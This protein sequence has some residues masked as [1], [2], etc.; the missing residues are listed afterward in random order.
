MNLSSV[1][2]PGTTV[3]GWHP[4]HPGIRTITLNTVQ[5]VLFILLKTNIT[6]TL[7]IELNISKH[8]KQEQQEQKSVK[9]RVCISKLV[10]VMDKSN[11]VIG[12]CIVMDSS[13]QRPVV[14]FIHASGFHSS[15]VSVTFFFW[16][17]TQ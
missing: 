7:H 11:V 17:Q 2:G 14:V 1:L 13:T 5:E 10:N 3:Q 4:E 9:V 15:L 12:E 6:A 16:H 8:Q